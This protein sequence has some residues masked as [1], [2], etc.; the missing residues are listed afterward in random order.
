[1]GLRNLLA[2]RQGPDSRSVVQ[3]DNGDSDSQ[4]E[5]P[6]KQCFLIHINELKTEPQEKFRFPDSLVSNFETANVEPSRS[7]RTLSTDEANDQ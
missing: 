6:D 4:K 5:R 2:A 7:R 1:V 3:N